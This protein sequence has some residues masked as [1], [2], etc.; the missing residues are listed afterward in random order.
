M[1]NIIE[2]N[3]LRPGD[4]ICRRTQN[5]AGLAIRAATKGPWNHDAIIVELPGGRLMIGDALMMNGCQLTPIYEWEMYCIR[6]KH[7]IIVLRPDGATYSDGKRASDWWLQ[8][9]HGKRYDSVAIFRL[10]LK[11]VFGDWFAKRVGLM[12]H[13][14]CTEGCRDAWLYGASINPWEPK[15]NATPGTTFKR[16]MSN[17]LIEVIDALTPTGKKYRVT[18]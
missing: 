18:C 1:S 6:R 5:L 16:F 13:F 8:N 12:S 15:E 14:F 3:N 17:R 9:V 4:I 10:G 7:R 2:R 11:A